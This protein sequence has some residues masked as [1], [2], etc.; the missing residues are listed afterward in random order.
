VKAFLLFAGFLLMI[1]GVSM[2]LIGGMNPGWTKTSIQVKK[3]DPVTDQEFVEWRKQFVPGLEFL[4]GSL[5]AG[6]I[7]SSLSFFI[8]KE[9]KV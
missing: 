9:K 3:T 5:L 4:A 1:A 6:S 2:W 8:R 7:L